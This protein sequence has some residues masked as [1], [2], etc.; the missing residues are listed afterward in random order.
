MNK[1]YTRIN[2]WQL[3][4]GLVFLAYKAMIA[5][6]KKGLLSKV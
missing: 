6:P 2:A 1:D 3:A 4:D 5:F